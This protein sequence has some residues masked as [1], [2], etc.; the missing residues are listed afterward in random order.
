MTDGPSASGGDDGV[1]VETEAAPPGRFSGLASPT[2]AL[3]DLLEAQH[4]LTGHQARRMGMG[5]TDMRAL[6]LLEVHGRLGASELARLLELRP[7]SVTSLVDRLVAASVLE[8]V[9]D[10]DDGRRVVIRAR[11]EALERSVAVWE[12]VI[13]SL[14]AIGRALSEEQRG[15]VAGYLHAITTHMASEAS[16]TTEGHHRGGLSRG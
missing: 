8:R 13:R 5:V 12:P 4:H 6:R 15:V 10:P 16:T 1:A 9:R 3:A 7:A 14:D 2:T 11:P